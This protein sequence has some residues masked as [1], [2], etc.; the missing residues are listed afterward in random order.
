MAQYGPH[1]WVG[2]EQS[3]NLQGRR[4]AVADLAG[5]RFVDCDLTGVKITDS[6]LVGVDI[7][8]FIGGL[9]INGVEVT[10]YVQAE[11]D[12]RHPERVQLREMRTA[13]DYRAMWATVERLWADASARAERLDE[14]ARHARIGGEWSLTE[15][16]RHL[17]FIADSWAAR[18]VLDEPAPFH[19]IGL[20]QTA[21]PPRDTVAL[22]IDLGAE[23]SWAEVI[24]VRAERIALV[25]GLIDGLTD[26]ELTRPVTRSPAPGYPDEERTAG[27]C[28]EVV[29][30][31]ECEHYRF[32]T[33][34][35]AV[36]EAG[37]PQQ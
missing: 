6:W 28:L 37:P 22:G 15:T 14:P 17:I 35:L 25:R 24:K 30:D 18:T 1:R 21:Y 32:A 9:T 36:L 5:A 29:M 11:L 20:P 3:E 4:F 23:P 33:R 8:G 13:D 19:R 12:R 27:G 34:D 31:E 26:D 2:D 10:G 16:L 7:S